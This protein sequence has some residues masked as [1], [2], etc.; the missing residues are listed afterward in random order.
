[1][2]FG[3][4]DTGVSRRIAPIR[5]RRGDMLE[6]QVERVD[7]RF[8]DFYREHYGQTVRLARMLTS[9]PDVAVVRQPSGL[10]GSRA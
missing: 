10:R 1:M 6:P 3:E 2:A 5:T 4:V 9:H 7:A 8:H